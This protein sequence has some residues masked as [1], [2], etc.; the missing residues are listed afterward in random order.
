MFIKTQQIFKDEIKKISLLKWDQ[1]VE[2][3]LISLLIN[4]KRII[5][6]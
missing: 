4:R 5:S 6:E 2:I 3:A 1:N